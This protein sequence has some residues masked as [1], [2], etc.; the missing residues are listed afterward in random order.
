M[1]KGKMTKAYELL[2]IRHQ[3]KLTQEKAWYERRA[4][5]TD[6]AKKLEEQ[7]AIA[8]KMLRNNEI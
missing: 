8:N 4:G 6:K 5:N 3:I 1:I 7:I 2:E